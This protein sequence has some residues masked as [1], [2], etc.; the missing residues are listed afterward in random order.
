MWPQACA[1][2][3]LCEIVT[4]DNSRVIGKVLYTYSNAAMQKSLSKHHKLPKNLSKSGLMHRF[5]ILQ[6]PNA[7]ALCQTGA[8]SDY[9]V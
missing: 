1:V 8:I 2:N 5:W 3:F 9:G 6:L 4:A 7:R